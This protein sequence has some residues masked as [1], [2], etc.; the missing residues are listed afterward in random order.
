MCTF[1]YRT[2]DENG[3]HKN[4]DLL[5]PVI[6]AKQFLLWFAP[7]DSYEFEPINVIDMSLTTFTAHN[8]NAFVK[9]SQTHGIESRDMARI[10]KR[11]TTKPKQKYGSQPLCTESPS[12][13]NFSTI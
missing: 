1:A 7:A 11:P 13:S 4:H 8:I 6:K 5:Q 10:T 12:A 2:R 9:E 3:P